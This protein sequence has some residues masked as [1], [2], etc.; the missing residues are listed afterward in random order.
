MALGMSLIDGNESVGHKTFKI[1]GSRNGM[2][3]CD[4]IYLEHLCAV[5]ACKYQIPQLDKMK[6]MSYL[7]TYI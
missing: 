6:T 3:Q 7:A 4:H 5:V 1:S 2:G